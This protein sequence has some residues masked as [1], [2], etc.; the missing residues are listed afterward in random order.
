MRE[1]K[2]IPNA[3]NANLIKAETT[4]F[5][6]IFELRNKIQDGLTQ[7]IKSSSPPLPASLNREPYVA[8]LS[9]TKKQSDMGGQVKR[10]M[11]EMKETGDFQTLVRSIIR[12][13][14]TS[15]KNAS[16][17]TQK[18]AYNELQE[19]IRYI[20][21]NKEQALTTFYGLLN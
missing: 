14:Y 9:N 1:L 13:I 21:S 10:M 6:N 3:N 19:K 5:A 16:F 7:E 15:V 18:H 17:S 11:Q 8:A 12:E 2:I 20:E 4:Y